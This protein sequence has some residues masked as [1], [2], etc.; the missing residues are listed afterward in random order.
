MKRKY[1]LKWHSFRFGFA[2]KTNDGIFENVE[3]DIKSEKLSDTYT[4]DDINKLRNI[5]IVDKSGKY[6]Y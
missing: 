2:F 5:L 3:Y 4:I 6:Q 1:E